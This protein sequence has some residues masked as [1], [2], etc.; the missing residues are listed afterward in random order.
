[1][2]E[3]EN[4]RQELSAI[5]PP[6]TLKAQHDLLMQV[7]RLG[8]TAAR[9]R[10]ESITTRDSDVVRNAASAAAGAILIL[11]RACVDL[12]CPPAPGR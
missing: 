1:M 6:E 4:L 10:F 12:S 3:F 8:T 2:Y 5:K 9:L 7:A 11:D